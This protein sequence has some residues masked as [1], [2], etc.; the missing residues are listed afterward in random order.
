M[1]EAA[2]EFIQEH[3]ILL[4][5]ETWFIKDRVVEIQSYKSL[6]F[7]RSA[8]N[9][10][11]LR[12]SGG[13]SIYIKHQIADN[14]RVMKSYLDCVVWLQMKENTVGNTRPIAMGVVYL[15]PESSVHN[16][17]KE[18]Y[19]MMLESD[20]AKF[21]T[22]HSILLIGDFNARTKCS[23]DYSP[24]IPGSE[25][26]V[27]VRII[28][29]APFPKELNCIRVSK[30][31][32]PINNF[33]KKLLDMCKMCNVRIL[34]GRAFEDKGR[35]NFT[36]MESNGCSV[37]DY[38][39]VDPET[40]N[41]IKNFKIS[42]RLPESDH[43]PVVVE[44]R[45]PYI[46]KE[47]KEIAR[48]CVYKYMCNTDGLQ[49]L[50]T[51]LVYGK[52]GEAIQKFYESI[53]QRAQVNEVADLWYNVFYVAM[54]STFQ[55]IPV[56]NK[57]K[58]LP[59]L[60]GE[61]KLLRKSIIKMGQDCETEN[62]IQ[63]VK[64][65]KSLVQKRKRA[66]RKQVLDAL[67]TACNTDSKGFW[68]TLK[69][70]SRGANTAVDID[71]TKV[72]EQLEGLS[73][74]P[75]EGYFDVQFER[76]CQAFL[77]EYD[78][79]PAKCFD[80]NDN[81]ILD[82]LN[83]NITVEE[84]V[85]A[86]KQLK[87]NKAPG[88]DLIPAEC[89]KASIH[90]IKSHLEILYNY[91]LCSGMYPEEW[92]AGLRVAIPKG[93]DDIRPITIEPI[94]GKIFEI[95]M[96]QRLTFIN[97]AFNRYD[98]YNGGF[99]K[100]SQTQDNMLVL[101]GC[102]QKQLIKGE[103]LF[104]GMVD[105]KKAFNYVNRSILFYKL[106]K[107]GLK[108]RSINVLR[109]MYCQIKAKVKIGNW[110]YDWIR[111][112]CGT[113]QGG[114]LSPSM[115]RKLLIDMR[116]FLNINHGIV[117]T[118]DETLVHMLWADDLILVADSKEGLQSQFDGLYRFCSKFQLIVN[119]IKTKVLVFGKDQNSTRSNFSFSFNGRTI[120]VCESYK[121]LGTIFSPTVNCR[122]NIFKEMIPYTVGQALK[123][124]FST[125]RKC[126]AVGKISPKIGFH[127]FD[128][129]VLPILD[130]ACEIW[131]QGKEH[132]SIERIQLKFIKML[133][134]VKSSTA[135]YAIYAETGRFPIFL[136]QTIK[137]VKYFVRIQNLKDNMIVKKVFIML[138]DLDALGYNT[139]FS[140]VRLILE[141]YGIDSLLKG[142]CC[143]SNI[144]KECMEKLK[145]QLF[146]NFS[147]K[148]MEELQNFP[149][150]RTYKK[151]KFEH[152]L[153]HYLVE[154]RDFKL[155]KV[156]AKFRL[157]GHSLEI[158]KGRHAKPKIPVEKRICTRCDLD[159]VEDELHMLTVCPFYQEERR[160]L[161]SNVDIG[162]CNSVDEVF[163]F[164]LLCEGK[165]P[166]YVAIF[167][168]KCFKKRDGIK[169][170]H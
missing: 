121:Y 57:V 42:P 5:Q 127:M 70:L 140:N 9:P 88:L 52:A 132:V 10:K 85:S 117:L 107:S 141:R 39:I 15:P 27:G 113:N 147:R 69:S 17:D 8:I 126:S 14:V 154:I 35:G 111:D 110:L 62:C 89:V 3:D 119:T 73:K 59:W 167:L 28:E 4:L 34:N 157:S 152:S 45:K 74:M 24:C 83:N 129:C 161:Y 7:I 55:K 101:I 144:V 81:C 165:V 151:F 60:D 97:N 87:N 25:A 86:V 21:K 64:E 49:A 20:I 91:I 168:H 104:V 50:P 164:I 105:F 116:N 32:G 37:I 6:H 79:D 170:A 31:Q 67:E 149:V 139:W 47:N 56:K 78:K 123:A 100:G 43:C 148:C 11:A 36:R 143:D 40:Y 71:P 120:E 2:G 48:T 75:V 153:E 115:F 108:G 19:F 30:D 51:N 18:D 130:Y 128:T 41:L 93:N 155:R 29:N 76:E 138:Q 13:I 94:F 26:D 125:L 131:S 145:D 16:V 112:E 166:F 122:G 106:I 1:Q 109:S 61:T 92:A 82:I 98:R 63:R 44:F 136:K 38:A 33:G 53:S 159:C 58:S 46:Q 77:K 23:E 102:I 150:L 169:P 124:C 158:E 163:N 142:G 12:G 114:P 162:H 72:Y 96:E 22:T 84:I 134:G 135:N 137:T 66:Y 156:L 133:L 95:I 68:K 118:E 103:P 54:D 99:I 146:N 90:V 80:E 65:Y 160:A